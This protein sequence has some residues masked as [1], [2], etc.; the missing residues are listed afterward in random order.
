MR[1]ANKRI[2][3]EPKRRLLPEN[4][5][6][7]GMMMNMKWSGAHIKKLMELLEA[8]HPD[9]GCVLEHLDPFQLIVAT[10]LSARCT[11]ERVNSVTPALFARYPNSGALAG[12]DSAELEAIIRPT[13]FFRNKARNLIKM[14][15]GLIQRHGGNVPNDQVT[16]E[17][18]PGVG[19]KT[20]NVVLANAFGI[21]ALAVDTHIFR[22]ARRLG[23][24]SANTPEKVEAD[25][26]KHFP[27]SAWIALHH[28][29]IWHG[30][31]VCH[32][33]SPKCKECSLSKLCA[34]GA[35]EIAD[36]HKDG[37]RT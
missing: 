17:A 37:T 14:A 35:D 31:L 26:C 7:L 28:Q 30:R 6:Q 8:A 15:Q 18:L 29:L 23:L 1:A 25:L 3:I 9:A 22:V 36:P 2:A 33:R 11:D 10:I 5:R 24:S 21:P 12:A 34:T 20:A 13:G 4:R 16:L 27:K 32:A 19:Q